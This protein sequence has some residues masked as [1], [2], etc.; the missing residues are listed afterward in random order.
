[1]KHAKYSCLVAGISLLVACGD[2]ANSGSSPSRTEP[3]ASPVV[4][5]SPGEMEQPQ[6][7]AAEMPPALKPK[8][9]VPLSQYVRV[10][11]G[12]DLNILY[13]VL[14]GL[15]PDYEELAKAVSSEYASERDGFRKSDLM[16]AL[17]P[18][19]DRRLTAARG[20]SGRYLKLSIQASLRPYDF[21]GGYFPVKPFVGESELSY[22][23][24]FSGCCGS[25]AISMINPEDYARFVVSDESLARDIERQISGFRQLRGLEVYGFAVGANLR[26]KSV[27][28]QITGFEGRTEAGTSVRMGVAAAQAPL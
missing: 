21:S 13:V 12:A 15:P 5:T 24:G 9:D 17:R 14:S 27:E 20:E 25:Q 28:L 16:K 26:R 11:D 2:G 10:E 4:T 7:K 6:Q 23:I 22:N 3:N 19:I 18:E 8:L 1:M